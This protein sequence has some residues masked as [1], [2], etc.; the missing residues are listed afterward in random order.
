MSL[1]VGRGNAGPPSSRSLPISSSSWVKSL[2][3]L[4]SSASLSIRLISDPITFSSRQKTHAAPRPSCRLL[5]TV[6]CVQRKL[7]PVHVRKIWQVS[8]ARRHTES[9]PIRPNHWRSFELSKTN[10]QPGTQ[11]NYAEN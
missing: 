5:P 11:E 9:R 6:F 10:V 1:V 4:F 2:R 3:R 8:P 7:Y